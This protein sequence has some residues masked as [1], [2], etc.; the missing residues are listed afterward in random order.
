MNVFEFRDKDKQDIYN[1]NYKLN[2]IYYEINFI[3]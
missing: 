2:N 1:I 3:Q